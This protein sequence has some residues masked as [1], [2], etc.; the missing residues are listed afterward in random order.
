MA[1]FR[2]RLFLIPVMILTFPTLKSDGM[3]TTRHIVLGL[4]SWVLLGILAID[5][6]FS[7]AESAQISQFR[8]EVDRTSLAQNETVNYRLIIEGDVT[9]VPTPTLPPLNEFQAYSSGRSQNISIVNGRIQASVTFNYILQPKQP[10]KFTIAPATLTV[11]GKTYQTQS[12]T[13]EVTPGRAPANMP[14]QGSRPPSSQQPRADYFVELSVDNDTPY[15]NEMITLSFRFYRARN[16]MGGLNYTKPKTNGFWS[17]DLPPQLDYRENVGGKTYLV[18][19]LRTA[20]FPT[21]SGTYTI[22]PATL[23]IRGTFF[24]AAQTLRSNAVTVKVKPLPTA[25]RPANFSGA[26]GQYRLS[27]K[28]SQTETDLNTPITLTV[29]LSGKGN[30]EMLS[31]PS[32]PELPDFKFYD[33]N[34]SSNVKT[35]NYVV[36]GSKTY[37][38]VLIPKRTGTFTI[39]P[40]TFSYFDPKSERYRTLKSE[41]YEIKVYGAEIDE[42]E[43]NLSRQDIRLL[44]RD[45][46]H[47]KPVPAVL[48]NRGIWYTERLS[49][50]LAI[51]L[52]LGGLIGVFGYQRHRE[53]LEADSGYARSRQAAKMAHKRLSTAKMHLTT[54]DSAAFHAEVQHA[55]THYLADK[56][57]VP[58]GS[59]TL[60]RVRSLPSIPEALRPTVVSILEKCDLARFAPVQHVSEM[61]ETLTTTQKLITDLDKTWNG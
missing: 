36:S 12:L 18:A 55:L 41:T 2:M 30:I 15:V 38:K 14:P 6:L 25:G 1:E 31:E 49:F 43:T 44:G 17:Q 33:S 28:V 5:G 26:V 37:E 48:Q 24:Q 35:D 59:I 53:R 11:D 61:S 46:R 7:V 13:I 42:R 45:I 52:P 9:N 22:E 29:T 10:G 23:Q 57:N 8:A 47:I 54:H 16:V 21:A 20:L 56:L 27:T 32:W 4:I 58:A 51:I 3:L 40:V 39:E 60:D 19:E 34:S 50:W